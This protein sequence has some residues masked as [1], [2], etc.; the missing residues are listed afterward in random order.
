MAHKDELETAIRHLSTSDPKLSG[1]IKR[2]GKCTISPHSDYY[3]ELV[4]SIVSQQLS[5]KAAATIWQRVLNVF[6]GYVPTPEQLIK[7]DPQKLRECGV[8]YQKISYMRDLA[9]HIIN[10]KLNLKHLS[11]LPDDELI[12]Q[13]V[14][15]KGIGEWSAHM[16]MIFSLGRLNVLP[17]GDLGI[18]KGVQNLYGLSELPDAKV[19]ESIAQKNKWAPYCSVAS[20]YIW[21]SLDNK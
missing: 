14:A 21:K 7:I 5:T 4:G 2:Y 13:L 3:G 17:V 10:G 6:N 16:F 15:V 1:V 12:E 8:S 18:K 19:I 11:G 20:W 9:E